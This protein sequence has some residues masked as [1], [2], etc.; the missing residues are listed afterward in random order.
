VHAQKFL[1]QRAFFNMAAVV[2]ARFSPH[3]RPT[4]NKPAETTPIRLTQLSHGGG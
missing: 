4:M 3:W 1:S 2:A